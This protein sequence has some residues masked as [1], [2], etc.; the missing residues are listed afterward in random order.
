[1][2]HGHPGRTLRLAC[3]VPDPTTLPSEIDAVALVR[4]GAGAA[5]ALGLAV[6][7]G[8]TRPLLRVALG[9]DAFESL[10]ARLG[11][12]RTDSGA[13]V[14]L[15]SDPHRLASS[16]ARRSQT[17]ALLAPPSRVAMD[18]YLEPRGDAAARVFLDLWGDR[19]L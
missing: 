12:F 2:E 15:I 8:A 4:S 3:F 18:L 6:I 10:P 17:G 16:D 7:F 9:G 19:E 1:M 5:E 13:N 11:G 14:L